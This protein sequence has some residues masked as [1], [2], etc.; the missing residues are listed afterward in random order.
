[1]C[2]QSR[3]TAGGFTRSVV[4]LVV[5]AI[6]AF[7]AT[8]A[9]AQSTTGTILGNVIDAGGLVLPGATVTATNTETGQIRTVVTDGQGSYSIPALQPGLYRVG[10][11]MDGFRPLQVDEFRL[12]AIQN[13]RVDVRLEL[14]GVAEQVN[15]VANAV[16]VETRSSAIVTNIDPQRVQQLPMLNRSMLQM[17]ALAPGITEVTVPEALVNSD[18][19]GAVVSGATGGR[20]N[21]NDIQLDGA[22]M[23]TTLYNRPSNLPTPDA[24]QEFQVL[25]N[26]YSAEFGRGGGTSMIAVTKSGTNIFR[27]GVWDYFRGDALNAKNY[28]AKS[29][30]YMNR[31]QFGANLGGPII[32]NRTFFFFNFEGLR[33][34]EE[35]IHLFFP[36]TAAMRAGNFS[37]NRFGQPMPETIYDPV[38]QVPFPGNVIP[39]DRI[40]PLARRILEYI[41]LP[42]EPNGVYNSLSERDTHGNQYLVKVDHRLSQANSFSVRYNHDFPTAPV[43]N[44]DVETF[45][46]RIGNETNAWNINDTHV[47]GTRMVGEGRVSLA[48]IETKGDLAPAANIHPRELGF[49]I[50]MAESDYAV[51]VPSVSASG[52]GGSFNFSATNSPWYRGSKVGQANYKVTW[53]LGGHSLKAGF[54]Y[55]WDW[56]RTHR[57]QTSTAGSFVN[58]GASTRRRSDG[59][60]GLGMADF[61]LG[62]PSSFTQSTMFSKTDQN[63]T[64]YGFVQDDI[65]LNRLT[66]NLGARF[67]NETPWVE[68]GDKTGHW[69][70]GQQ[71]TRY[72]Q[73][74]TNLVYV[75]DEGVRPGVVPV[76]RKLLPRLGFAYD[77]RGDGRMAIRG[78]YG[79]F[80]AV[81]EA[82]GISN[83]EEVPPFHTAI[84]LLDPYTLANPW[85]PNR[86][87][88]FPFVRNAR[89]E[90]YFPTEP[91]QLEMMDPNWQ[92]G[93]L[94]QFNVMFQQQLGSQTV[95]SAAYVGSRARGLTTERDVNRAV[96][97]PGQSTTQNI[98]SRRPNNKFGS[99]YQVYGGSWTDYNSLQVTASKQY[100]NNYTMQLTYT[101]SRVYD[102]GNVGEH[103]TDVMDPSNPELD[104]GISSVNRTHV[105]RINGLYEFPQL[106]DKPSAVRL[107]VGG[108]R[109]A[110][111]MSYLS[112]NMVNV[113]SGVDR[114][115]TG[116]G[117]CSPQRPNLTGDPTLPGNRSQDEKIAQWFNANTTTLWTLPALGQYG[118]APRNAIRGPDRFTLDL[119][120]TKVF[121][122]SSVHARRGEVRIEAF[123]VTNRLNLDNPD[124]VRNSATFGQI[125]SAGAQ[126]IVQLGLRFEF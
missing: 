38:T 3:C 90:G 49:L 108:W 118:N 81:V 22:S 45:Y 11:T 71:S 68:E 89:G 8:P 121:R 29:K 35:T 54:E 109:L 26:S 116:C 78:G 31:H 58:N 27:G 96:F 125:V 80:G 79:M 86:V 101:L 10:V 91:I 103:T 17:V 87:S 111:I 7:A 85:G 114:A 112:G 65:R 41:P 32:P 59:N 83:A 99:V 122:L 77:V 95:V 33:L 70:P 60:G 43:T 21:Q 66:L 57:Q 1:M 44:T 97:I 69:V 72:P 25:T 124:G 20:T 82:I 15:V 34:K 19:S 88:V 126:R 56:Q 92:P 73:A 36:P 28:F 105:L 24:I 113:T 30:P 39:A 55:E 18:Q 100:S 110:G 64:A 119:S 75:G 106:L 53:R 61:L 62:R 46:T 6:G 16:R 40:D 37:V 14:A 94:H 51:K 63:W 23:T 107:A 67:S 47:F 117:F 2:N 76:T 13:A 123:N 48:I 9:V 98:N 4:V 104:R 84:T 42:N 74:P 115:L 12:S 50:D 5:L 93:N 52:N 102:D 120:L